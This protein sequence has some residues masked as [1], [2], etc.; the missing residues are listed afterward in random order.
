MI[1]CVVAYVHGLK[2]LNNLKKSKPFGDEIAKKF[3]IGDLVTWVDWGEDKNGHLLRIIRHGV[4]TNIVHKELGERE[5]VFACILPMNS[6]Q[7]IELS[8]S[9]IRKMETN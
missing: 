7:N 9:K 6:D 2:R 3:N 1:T 5:V 8:I 4:L